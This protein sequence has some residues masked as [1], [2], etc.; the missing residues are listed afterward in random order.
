MRL[1]RNTVNRLPYC[2]PVPANPL[3]TPQDAIT[4]VAEMVTEYRRMTKQPMIRTRPRVHHGVFGCVAGLN[5]H[6]HALA[7]AAMPLWD[8]GTAQV[9]TI[10]L[11]RAAFEC[12]LL[13]QWLVRD[14]DALDAVISEH[15][16]QVRALTREMVLVPQLREHAEPV[17]AS[18]TVASSPKAHIARSIEQIAKQFEHGTELY[19]NYRLLCGFTHAGIQ[20]V[21][22]WLGEPHPAASAPFTL[23]ADREPQPAYIIYFGWALLFTAT[24]FGDLVNGQVLVP[25]GGQVEVP[26]LRSGLV[27]S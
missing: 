3:A 25:A 4:V 18:L 26:V 2:E 8:S 9:A 15:E 21:E 19:A 10:P 16:R 24:A 27:S 13:A 22:Q 17:L 7:E 6:A 11:A 1:G 12:G 23:R 14:P 20:I 5:A